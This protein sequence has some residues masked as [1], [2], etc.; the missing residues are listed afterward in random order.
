MQPQTDS[1]GQQSRGFFRSLADL[2]F[3]SFVTARVIKFIYVISVLFTVIY[4]LF[5]TASASTFVAGFVSATTDSQALGIVAGAVV[6]VLLAP[7][8]LLIG[9]TYVRVLLE[10]VVVMFRISENTAEV[11]RGIRNMTPPAGAQT[12]ERREGG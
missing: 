7:L 9:V 3:T 12:A 8:L 4:V 5:I 6:F 11:A 2:S 10:I 1:I